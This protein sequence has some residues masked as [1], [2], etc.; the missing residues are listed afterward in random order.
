[1]VEYVV[2][3][4]CDIWPAQFWMLLPNEHQDGAVNIVEFRASHGHWV[5]EVQL[6]GKRPVTWRVL[7][8]EQANKA[9]QSKAKPKTSRDV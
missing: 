2:E 3:D 7:W 9:G 5:E 6:R 8:Y 1:M 4:F